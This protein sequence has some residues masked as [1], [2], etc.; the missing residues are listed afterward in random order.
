MVVDLEVRP[1][2]SH[3]RSH[4][5]HRYLESVEYWRLEQVKGQ[6][7]AQVLMLMLKSLLNV[8]PELPGQAVKEEQ[9]R[10]LRFG[11]D[12]KEYLASPIALDVRL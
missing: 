3:H 9:V 10:E 4:T 6:I 7:E 11:A 8:T 12:L 5:P 2:G 1:G